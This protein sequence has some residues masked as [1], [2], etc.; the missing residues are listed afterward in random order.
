M[1]TRIG[2]LVLA[3]LAVAAPGEQDEGTRAALERSPLT[4]FHY[5]SAQWWGRPVDVDV[6]RTRTSGAWAGAV[7]HVRTAG[8]TLAR[9]FA[10]LRRRD[11]VWRVTVTSSP[12]GG[13][14]C[15]AAPRAVVRRLFGFCIPRITPISM[16]V[17]PVRSRGATTAERA[18]VVRAARR[19]VF[20]GHDRCVRYGVDVSRVDA[21]FARVRYR[22]VPPLR[23]CLV[24]NGD[25]LFRRTPS[26]RWLHVADAS[27]PF[28]C[29]L[30]PA[31]VVRSLLGTCVILGTAVRR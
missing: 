17:G 24:G 31:G 26:G 12:P 14:P 9:Q 15:E 6:A 10:L 1:A 22:F 29:D 20:G 2:L 11:G 5:G 21:R 8:R 25:S 19:R 7:L 3:A 18:A 30:A 27:D 4:Y 23:G 13:L 28:E 16:I